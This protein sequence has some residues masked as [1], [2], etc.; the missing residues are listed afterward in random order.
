MRV[1]VQLIDHG[2]ARWASRYDLQGRDM[3]RFE[4]D[5][6]QKVV[7]GLSVQ[8]SG[9]EQESLKAPSTNSTEA[10]SFLLQGRAYQADYR[11]DGKRETLQKAEQMAQ[12]AIEKDP[13]FGEAFALL[14]QTLAL[15]ATNYRG[16]G[17]RNLALAEQPARKAAHLRPHSLAANMALGSV[18]GEQG[19]NADAIQIVREATTLGPNSELAWRVL[20]YVYH[21]AGLIDQAEAAF[22]RSR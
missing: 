10:Y 18:Y 8:L 7:D 17:A 12:R 15:E 16:N 1:S 4:D 14:G 11:I 6:A 13:A 9:A 21:Y 5:I 3:L 20:G 19:K 22:R 2:A